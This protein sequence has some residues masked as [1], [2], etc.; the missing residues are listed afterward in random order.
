MRYGFNNLL[1]SLGCL[2]VVFLMIYIYIQALFVLINIII[3]AR[4]ANPEYMSFNFYLTAKF[5]MT[6]H[7]NRLVILQGIG[8]TVVNYTKG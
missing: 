7:L 4:K 6:L 8:E 5:V 2:D 3:K 1:I